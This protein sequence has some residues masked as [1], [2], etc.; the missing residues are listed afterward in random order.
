M[1]LLRHGAIVEDE[2]TRVADA[3]GLADPLPIIVPHDLWLA[4][5]DRLLGRTQPLGLHLPAGQSPET[6]AEDIQRFSLIAV[7]FPKFTDGRGFSYGRLLRERLGYRR[8]LRAVGQVLRDQFAFILRCGFDS[9]EIAD[10]DDPADWL[11]AAAAISDWYQPGSDGRPT[12][13]RRRAHDTGRAFAWQAAV[14]S[15]KSRL[16]LRRSTGAAAH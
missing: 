2:W 5:R 4:H 8:E 1:P 6:L 9:F 12:I 16:P 15:A 14:G 13:Q 10:A 3:S 7:A 11:A